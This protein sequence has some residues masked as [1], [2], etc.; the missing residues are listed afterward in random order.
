MAVESLAYVP[1]EKILDY[2]LSESHPVGSAKAR[3]FRM[4]G[5]SRRNWKRLADA[6]TDHAIQNDM[7]KTEESRFGIKYIVKGPLACPTGDTPVVVTVWFIAKG[8][9]T[10]R[11]VT[12]FPAAKEE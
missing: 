1:T 9:E 6:L 11:L 12:A 4:H 8:E 2:L 7:L 10:P 3:F 5:Y